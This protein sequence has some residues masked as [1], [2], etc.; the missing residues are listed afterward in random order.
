MDSKTL[1]SRGVQHSNRNLFLHTE[2]IWCR[3]KP[4]GFCNFG[5]WA[6]Y[7]KRLVKS[8]AKIWNRSKKHYNEWNNLDINTHQK[9]FEEFLT[10]VERYIKLKNHN[11]QNLFFFFNS[12][13]YFFFC[14]FFYNLNLFFILF[15]NF[16]DRTY[17]SL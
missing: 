9:N 8:W 10:R 14:F 1:R 15:K 6:Y 13:F 16:L 3:F 4:D 17:W 2:P 5:I 11:F 7:R 12:F